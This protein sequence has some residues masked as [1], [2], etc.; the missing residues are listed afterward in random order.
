MATNAHTGPIR[1]P[2][3]GCRHWMGERCLYE[4]H[5]NPGLRRNFRC[6]VLEDWEKILEEHMARCRGFESHRPRHFSRAQQ[7]FHLSALF[8]TDFS[9]SPFWRSATAGFFAF[10]VPQQTSGIQRRNAPERIHSVVT[11]DVRLHQVTLGKLNSNFRFC[12]GVRV[13]TKK[14]V[15]GKSL[16]RFSA[17]RK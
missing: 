17:L 16:W 5:L 10:F 14:L 1:L 2:G 4:E 7:S 8:R 11:D 6:T 15:C 9:S 12:I 3:W 13:V